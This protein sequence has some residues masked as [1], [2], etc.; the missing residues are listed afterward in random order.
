MVIKMRKNLDVWQRDLELLCQQEYIPWELLRNK[1]ILVTGA[2]GLIG[3]TMIKALA[4]V[5]RTRQLDIKIL[6]PVRSLERAGTQFAQLLQDTDELIFMEGTVER[7]PT[8]AY[9]VHYIIHGASPTASEYFIT[10]PVETIKTAVIGTI[11]LLELAK[12]KKVES[13]VYL[14]SMEIYGAPRSEDKLTEQDLGYINPLIVRNCY[15]E[16]KRQ[17]ES[18]CASY[19]DEFDVRCMSIRLAQTF[20]PGVGREDVRVFAE[21]ARCAREGKDIVLLTDGGSKRCYLYTFDAVS[22]ILTVLLKGEKGKAYNAAN[23]ETYCSVLEMA[24]KVAQEL[25]KEKIAVKFADNKERSLKFPPPHFYNLDID[26]LLKLGWKP[27][28]NLLEMY[29]NMMCTMEGE[30]GENEYR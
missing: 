3:S 28:K 20:G 25:S 10:K 24:D 21:F 30:N 18:L 13:F 2:T 11:N 4:Y 22:A 1:N 15:P 6:A 9:P 29:Q 5:N 26:E 8:I 12:E 7:L 14:S 19:A 16:A 17:C 23:P 27:T